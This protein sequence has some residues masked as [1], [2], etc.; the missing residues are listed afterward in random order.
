M[1]S[2][3]LGGVRGVWGGADGEHVFQRRDVVRTFMSMQKV[4]TSAEEEK[5]GRLAE[6]TQVKRMSSLVRPAEGEGRLSLL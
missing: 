4:G 2:T 1:H 3:R 6:L 5:R